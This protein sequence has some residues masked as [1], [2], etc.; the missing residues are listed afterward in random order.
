[1]IKFKYGMNW[2]KLLLLVLILFLICVTIY[3]I[4][5]IGQIQDCNHPVIPPNP[6]DIDFT[7]IICVNGNWM[8]EYPIYRISTGV[9]GLVIFCFL[10]WGLWTVPV[11]IETNLEDAK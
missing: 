9:A 5:V 1:M 4:F 10:F 2:K 3:G 7:Y 11:N 6:N 8:V